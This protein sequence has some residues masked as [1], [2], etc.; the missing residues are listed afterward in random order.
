MCHWKGRGH[1]KNWVTFLL[2]FIV[3]SLGM[4]FHFKTYYPVLPIESVSKRE[5]INKAKTSNENIVKLTEENGYEWYISKMKKGEA[6]EHL[7]QMMTDKGWVYK[8]Q[9]GAGFIFQQEDKELIIVSQMWTKKYVIFQ[10]PKVE[11]AY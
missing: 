11:T 4:F 3:I 1:M 5:V 9:M 7:K 8:E 10:V 6:Y 2:L